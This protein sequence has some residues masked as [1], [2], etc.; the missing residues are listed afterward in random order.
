MRSSNRF[1]YFLIIEIGKDNNVTV[2]INSFTELM[3]NFTPHIF[4]FFFLFF[5]WKFSLF[6]FQTL[7]PFQISPPETPYPILPPPA[8]RRVLPP[9]SLLPSCLGMPLHWGI[10]PLRPKGCSSHWCPT[11]PSSAT[12]ALGPS[13]CILWLVFQHPGAPGSLAC[14]HFY[15]THGA[16][17]PL[18]SFSP[19]SNSSIWDFLHL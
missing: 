14:W 1:N 3:N 10:D 15:S 5:Y 9:H 8:S 19:F 17:N 2:E 18:S 16:A 12:Y 4:F 7:S 6:T 13:M 11:R